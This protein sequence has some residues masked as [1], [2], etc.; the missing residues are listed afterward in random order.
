MRRW[1]AAVA[2]LPG[3]GCAHEPVL[4]PTPAAPVATGRLYTQW[5]HAGRVDHQWARFSSS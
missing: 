5:L 3:A 2:T 1:I 4:P